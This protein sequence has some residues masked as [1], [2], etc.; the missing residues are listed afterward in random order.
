MYVFNY[1]GAQGEKCSSISIVLTS[2]VERSVV[3]MVDGK[4]QIH[5]FVRSG[6]EH[7]RVIQAEGKGEIVIQSRH[8]SYLRIETAQIGEAC[9]IKCRRLGNKRRELWRRPSC[10][11]ESSASIGMNPLK[12]TFLFSLV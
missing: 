7:V 3:S 6:E 12:Q 5:Q 1:V 8:L 11:H 10:I 4:T 9:E 2:L